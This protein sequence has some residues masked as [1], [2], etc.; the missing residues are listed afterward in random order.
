MHESYVMD[1]YKDSDVIPI[2]WKC[3]SLWPI[4]II[5]GAFERTG[6]GTKGGGGLR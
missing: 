3:L 6:R 2:A 4:L 1:G 5:S